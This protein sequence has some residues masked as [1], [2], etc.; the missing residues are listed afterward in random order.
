[1][2]DDKMKMEGDGLTGFV[3]KNK[4]IVQ[5][6]LYGG[7]DTYNCGRMR[8]LVAD[9]M[10]KFED[11]EYEHLVLNLEGVHYIS[12]M[13]FGVLTEIWKMAS[14]QGKKLSIYRVQ[15]KVAEVVSLLGLTRYFNFIES[16]RELE[17]PKPHVFPKVVSCPKC[18]KKYRVKKDGKYRC[19]NCKC[20]FQVFPQ[21]NAQLAR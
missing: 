9:V 17:E 8:D 7:V 5:V 4:N 14:N 10:V 20:L 19:S 21:G 18:G 16:F 12:S 3:G 15:P 11:D 6:N 1:M 2:T 13:G